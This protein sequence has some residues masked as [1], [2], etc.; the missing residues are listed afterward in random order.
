MTELKIPFKY[1]LSKKY[2]TL[3]NRVQLIQFRLKRQRYKIKN[4][5]FEEK[6]KANSTITHIK[7]TLWSIF[8]AV[9][10]VSL[11]LLVENF[12]T[13]YWQTHLR[14]FPNWL[15]KLQEA[16]PKPTYPDDRDAIIELIS[17]IASVTGVIL[18]LFYPILATIASTAYAKVH[19]SIRN[20]LLYEKETQAYLRR[21]TYL[22]ASSIT[23]LLCLTFGFLPGNLLLSFLAFYSLTTLF[24]ILKIGLGV[25][26]FFEPSTL[27]GIVFNKLAYSMKN[28]TT[29]GEYWNEKNFQNHHYKL[30][31]E[32]TEN[33][34]LLTSL[35]LKDDDLKESSFKSI[36][37]TSLY[38]LQFYL[39]QK[40]KIPIDSLWF[41]NSYE[42]LSYFE[43]DMSMR[44]LS[45]NTNTL[46]QPKVKP[47]RYWLEERIVNNLSNGLESVVKSG[48]I[49]VLG[50]SILMTHSVFDS[51]SAITDL[52]TGEIL[53]DKLLTNVRLIS[54]KKTKKDEITNYDNWKEELGCVETY[55][56]AT[57]RL[58]V[59]VFETI[60]SF[61]SN[62]ILEEYKKI[63]WENKSTIYS[64]K[65]LPEL[66]E[67]LNKFREFVE[68]EREIEGK[69][70]TPDW[71][72]CQR[73][74]ADYLRLASEKITQ[75]ITFFDSHLLTLAKH[76]DKENNC[77]L[78]SFTAQIG[79][80]IL[81]KLHYRIGLLKQTLDDIDKIEVCKGEFIWTKPNFEEIEAKLL[82]Y[83]SD[84][85]TIIAK[86]VEKLASVKWNNQFPDVFAHSYSLLSNKLNESYRK[87]QFDVFQK[88]FA[89]F[90]RSSIAAFGNLNTTFKHYDRPQNISY[91]ALL[92]PME[93]SGYAYIYSAI[94]NSP[95]YW[96]EV[97]KAW[98]ESFLPSKENIALLV[99]YYS[100]YKTNLYGTG[101]NYTNKHQRE[102]TLADVTQALNIRV[103]DIPDFLV[104][105]FVSE[106]PYHH[107]FY[108]VAELFIELYLFTFIEAKDSTSKMKRDIFS[109]LNRNINPNP[110]EYDF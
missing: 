20:L 108:D 50:E 71:Y 63:N 35:C 14:S 31:F 75:S 74:T 45:I 34:S 73:L 4:F 68:N 49:N 93:I 89:P 25:Y 29:E 47:N 2:W 8:K 101:I 57:L 99:F 72:F 61:N 38:T 80:E 18:A 70:I 92:D 33:L 21:L 26:N 36:F 96:E 58:Q 97:K 12:T 64:T 59:G 66:Y 106:D 55:C 54:N 88:C 32:Q 3:K 6:R 104:R 90:L 82:K 48:H 100:Y 24:G 98:D 13:N 94:Y 5:F 52:R 7:L 27:S 11:I 19:A 56:Y 102:R 9:G 110:N 62:R 41:P 42:H 15:L 30:A 85:T 86:N 79:L 81:H 46:T 37:K 1:T 84:C 51:L 67:T 43:S 10:F 40:P 39:I 16:L 28:V 78:A 91:Q 103:R 76:F 105:L 83:D 65:L 53:L 44:Q 95:N 87:N 17:V 60:T 69:R 77:L 107:N 23:V 109:Q 22:T